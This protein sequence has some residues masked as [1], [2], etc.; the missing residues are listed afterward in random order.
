MQISEM[1]ML[2]RKV[3]D[4][5]ESRTAGSSKGGMTEQACFPLKSSFPA[6]SQSLCHFLHHEVSE[7]HRLLAVLEAQM[8]QNVPNPEEPATGARP[9]SETG[10]TLLRLSLWT[11]DIKLKMRLVAAV[12]DDAQCGFDRLSPADASGPWWCSCL[13]DPSTHP[14]R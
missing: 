9:E 1:G 11:E 4:F 13:E 2:Y 14:A 12:V 5:V 8:S 7:C 10:L 3:T 6:D